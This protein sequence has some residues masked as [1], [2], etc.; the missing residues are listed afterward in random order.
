MGKLYSTKRCIALTLQFVTFF[1]YAFNVSKAQAPP[2]LTFTPVITTGFSSPLDIVNANDGTN[3]LFIA[4]RSGKVRIVSG[5][6][7][8]SGALLDVR[9]SLP[10]NLG[11]E[12]GLLSIA[13]HPDYATNGYLFIYYL[14]TNYDV[15][16]TR[17]K[18]ANPI[19][20]TP[21]NQNTGTVIMTI[22]TLTTSFHNGGKMLFGPDGHLYFTP[23]DGS[24]GGDPDNHAQNGNILWG[25]MI[26]INVD[27]FT[28]PPYYTIPSDNPFVNDPAIR[29]E[30][31]ALGLRN[32]WR[33]SF[34]RLN[35]D[36]WLA[37]VGEAD[38]EEVNHHTLATAGGLNY[39]WR[40][41]EGN[42]DFNTTG[43]LAQ[44]N[45]SFPMFVY[46]HNNATGG[47]S[48]IG[49]HVYRGTEYAA[50]Y[51]YYIC[52]DYVSGNGW[53]IKSNGSGGWNISMQTSLPVSIVGFGEA[54]NGALYAVTLTGTLYKVTTNSGGPLPVSLR[55]FTAKM[56]MGYNELK[57]STTNEQ[58]VM[59]YEVEYSTDS[60]SYINA[61]KVNAFNTPL[62]NNYRFNHFIFSFDR[63]FYRLK[64][65]NK[66]GSTEYSNIIELNK[67]QT[68]SVRIY[69]KPITNSQLKFITQ[70]P[71][72]EVQ[73]Y[74]ADGQK[75]FQQNLGGNA[76][77]FTL[78]L[79]YLQAGVYILRF[80]IK[81]EYISEKLLMG[82][83]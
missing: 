2:V 7:L 77:S 80:R 73:L 66:N 5:G 67:K 34:D 28:T 62:E 25:K 14:T 35:N 21:I 82:G 41:Y 47:F 52:A 45:Y 36:M 27:D 74:A 40:C 19:T 15:R 55:S 43:C 56:H 1:L 11:E 18:A 79:P 44:T 76:G 30:I 38:W 13:F 63:L 22:P 68:G 69:P 33:W 78:R 3:R 37:D 71:L 48:I 16:I 46:P 70:R 12:S 49:G 6:V 4:E 51:G 58:D 60:R 32:A 42:A 50:L 83:R 57:W 65:T 39:G 72:D 23:G 9:D 31:Y 10:G 59:Q 61:G 8:L 64:T 75:V 26:R 53:L 54:E 81:N 29:D 20:N 24:P 17:F